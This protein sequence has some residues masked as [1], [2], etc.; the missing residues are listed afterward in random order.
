MRTG[1]VESRRYPCRWRQASQ[2][3]RLNLPNRLNPTIDAQP[4]VSGRA[5]RDNPVSAAPERFECARWHVGN[6]QRPS[7]PS[8]RLRV[9]AREKEGNASG[10]GLYRH[11]IWR[12][13]KVHRRQ[14]WPRSASLASAK[15]CWIFVDRGRVMSSSRGRRCPSIRGRTIRP[16]DLCE[17]AQ[18]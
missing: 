7:T 17:A 1:Y 6:L 3:K 8:S 11:K 12:V 15:R 14:T 9:V 18:G 4:Q 5:S 2:R 13:T 16:T 10:A